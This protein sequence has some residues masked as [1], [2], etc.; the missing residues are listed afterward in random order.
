MAWRL[1]SVLV[2]VGAVVV[3]SCFLVGQETPPPPPT[4]LTDAP[5]AP[6]GVEVLARG[7]IHEAFA[8]PTTEPAASSPIPRQPPKPLDELPPDTKPA[9]DVNWIGGYWAW[10]DDRKDFLW[11]SGTWRTAPPGRQWVAGYWRE[12]GGAWQWVAGY[13]G[14]APPPPAPGQPVQPVRADNFLPAPPATPDAVPPGAAP[15]ADAFFIPGYWAYN[16]TTYAWRAGYWARVQPGYV[17]VTAHYRWTP[18]GYV[19]IPGYWDF[20]VSRRGVLYAPVVISPSVVTVG[21]VYTPSYAVRDTL[22]LDTLFVRPAYSHYY[23]GDYY[24]PSYERIGFVSCVVYSRR[25]YDAV[26]VYERY[27]HRANPGWEA[28]YLKITVDRHAGLAPLPP[29]TLVVRGGV[30]P[31][32]VTARLAV[33][34][35]A[36]VLDHAARQQ[37]R[38]RSAEV[39]HATAQR[40][41]VESAVN[42]APIRPAAH[43]VVPVRRPPPRDPKEK[44]KPERP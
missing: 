34:P 26:F 11:V 8:A 3:S 24:G 17:W 12:S 43:P 27:E 6:N 33:G 7:P 28:A 21:Y 39:A 37:A 22:V 32:L 14:P 4:A 10:D 30:A 15:S 40:A 31:G 42:R 13:W 23:F 38:I 20:T 9:G 44:Q 29:R 35:R 36:V 41:R 1:S 19:F 18:A 5:A 25:H 16:G 2:A